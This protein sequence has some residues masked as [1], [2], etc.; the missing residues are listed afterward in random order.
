MKREIIRFIGK[1][2]FLIFLYGLVWMFTLFQG[3]EAS[4]FLTYFVSFL[5]LILLFVSISPLRSWKIKHTFQKTHYVAGETIVA[6]LKLKRNFP[7]FQNILTIKQQM[8][9]KNNTPIW[10]EQTVS[11]FFKKELAIVL[12]GF[13]AKRGRITFAIIRLETADPFHLISKSKESKSTESLLIYPPYRKSIALSLTDSL[14]NG[15]Q[16]AQHWSVMKNE[17]IHGLRKFQNGDRIALI[18]WK[19]SAKKEELFMKEFESSRNAKLHVFFHNIPSETYEQALTA[20]YSFV[21]RLSEQGQPVTLSI[22]TKNFKQTGEGKAFTEIIAHLFATLEPTP[23]ESTW[24]LTEEVTIIFTPEIDN[25]IQ[26]LI[27]TYHRHNTLKI[28]T[29]NP[30]PDF[31]SEKII[32]LADKE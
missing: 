30:L 17:N 9:A 19:T 14:S 1:W 28:V 11:P 25:A 32:V 6:T 4:W 8:Q 26:Q 20:C 27:H 22:P 3:D 18:D 24:I 5:L 13:T 16:S 23:T 31:H 15:E 7:F 2:I 12:P 10:L 21:R 29:A